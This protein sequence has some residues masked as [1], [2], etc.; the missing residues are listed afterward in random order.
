VRAP[1]KKRPQSA[2]ARVSP[3]HDADVELV[4]TLRDTPGTLR[5]SRQNNSRQNRSFSFDP[6]IHGIGGTA[7]SQTA[8]SKLFRTYTA[9][10]SLYSAK[11]EDEGTRG[12]AAS[13][14]RSFERQR[15]SG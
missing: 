5:S 12:A 10:G 13:L 9:E 15:V 2:A 4:R 8:S 11:S 6:V 1:P 7:P 3:A 14:I